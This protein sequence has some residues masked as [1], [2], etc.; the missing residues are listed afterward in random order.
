MANGRF[1]RDLQGWHRFTACDAP[2]GSGAEQ[3]LMLRLGGEG[4][5]ASPLAADG[6]NGE[7]LIRDVPL[8][9]DGNNQDT[10]RPRD[11]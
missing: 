3:C 1:R 10:F 9:A 8:Q 11:S 6:F 5:N 7:G 4:E 2:N